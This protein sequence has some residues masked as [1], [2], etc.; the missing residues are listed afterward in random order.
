M[1]ACCNSSTPG[2]DHRGQ[3]ETA[4]EG[5]WGPEEPAREGLAW[6]AVLAQPPQ[7]LALSTDNHGD[8]MVSRPRDRSTG[9]G[10]QDLV[11][12]DLYCGPRSTSP[13]SEVLAP[14]ASGMLGDVRE[15]VRTS[16]PH[17]PLSG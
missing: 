17:F 15:G 14:I 2:T 8:P 4:S 13:S 6:E 1:G 3:A 11:S 9:P 16:K 7:G 5:G 12:A 10:I